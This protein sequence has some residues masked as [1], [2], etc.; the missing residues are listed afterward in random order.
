M[1]DYVSTH[2]SPME[3]YTQKEWIFYSIGQ[4]QNIYTFI[5]S[6]FPQN[7]INNSND[8]EAINQIRKPH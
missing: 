1:M 6:P 7:P 4:K 3:Q 2:H 5:A 8:N